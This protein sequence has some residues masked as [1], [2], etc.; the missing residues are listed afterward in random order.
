[1]IQALIKIFMEA[2][3]SAIARNS[4]YKPAREP[5]HKSPAPDIGWGAKLALFV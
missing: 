4:V 3:M 5:V 2:E 1:M